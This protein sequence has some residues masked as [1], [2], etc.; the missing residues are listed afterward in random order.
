MF[1]C[2]PL[3]FVESTLRRFPRATCRSSS[4]CF[5]EWLRSKTL[6]GHLS[7]VTLLTCL[8]HCLLSISSVVS[9]S[10]CMPLFISIFRFLSG[11]DTPRFVHQMSTSVDNRFLLLALFASH[12]SALCNRRFLLLVCRLSFCRNFYTLLPQNLTQS[13]Y[14]ALPLFILSTYFLT[15]VSICIQ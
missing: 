14:H 8:N 12:P 10:A 5:S 4:P 6:F 15:A 1:S 7:V 9:L 11:R 13:F 3:L 2:Q